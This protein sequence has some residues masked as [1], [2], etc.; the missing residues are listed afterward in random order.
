[1]RGNNNAPFLLQ[2]DSTNHMT[3]DVATVRE[4]ILEHNWLY[5]DDC[6]PVKLL[7][8]D[9]IP[10]APIDS[11]P[12][13]SIEF[14]EKY[15]A[16][17]CGQGK[18]KPICI[19]PALLASPNY[20]CRKIA[21]AVSKSD[22]MKIIAEW[23]GGGESR[24]F[25]KSASVLKCDYADLY[26]STDSAIGALPEDDTFFVSEF[27]GIQSEW[28]AFVF[29]DHIEDIRCYAGDMWLIPDRMQVEAMV[30][31]VAADEHPDAYTLDVAVAVC[32]DRGIRSVV[33]EVH[34]FVACGLY[35]FSGPGLIPMLR[36]GFAYARKEC[37]DYFGK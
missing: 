9:D 18:L 23:S 34:N 30:E 6:L 28:R 22:L 20:M 36:R 17:S 21:P 8:I 3:G 4:A 27:L 5:P 2:I 33:I 29:K 26:R 7:N 12:V 16:Q 35:G 32:P 14:V 37:V 15:L 31:T 11:C 24:V 10:F 13:G 1:M 19:P 25:I